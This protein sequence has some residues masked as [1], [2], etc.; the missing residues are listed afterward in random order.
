MADIYNK[1]TITPDYIQQFARSDNPV[2]FLSG[3]LSLGAQQQQAGM[4]RVKDINDYLDQQFQASAAQLKAINPAFDPKN[5]YVDPNIVWN[6]GEGASANRGAP[7]VQAQIKS[8]LQ[9]QAIKLAQQAAQTYQQTG[10]VTPPP[11]ASQ[12]VNQAWQNNGWTITDSNFLNGIDQRTAN[13]IPA[14]QKAALNAA[15][16]RVGAPLPYPKDQIG[17]IVGGGVFTNQD[18]QKALASG[19]TYDQI[20]QQAQAGTFQSQANPGFAAGG[21]GAPQGSQPAAQQANITPDPNN[22]GA[23]IFQGKSYRDQASA[24]TAAQHAGVPGVVGNGSGAGGLTTSGQAGGAAGTSQPALANNGLQAALDYLKNSNLDPAQ[25]DIF[26]SMLNDPA[27]GDKV[28]Y[29]SVV[30][31]LKNFQQNTLDPYYQEVTKNLINQTTS[32]YQ[33]L[34]QNRNLE[35]TQEGM[36]ADQ[37]IR[38]AKSDL[39]SRGMTFS[40]EGVRQLGNQSAFAQPGQNPN[41]AIPTQQQLPGG[42]F[43]EGLIPKQNQLIASSSAARY[44]QGLNQLSQGLESTLGT[45]GASG[46]VPG[47]QLLGGVTDRTATLPSQKNT[48]L[49]QGYQGILGNVTQNQQEGQNFNVFN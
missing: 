7:V 40:G 49:A 4:D 24:M 2:Q 11:P 19:Q 46:I 36:N 32:A 39:E 41:N 33:N 15:A 16:A 9:Q 48:Q 31:A 34:Q 29:N 47:G 12:I 44:Q 45:A 5:Y 18:I 37:N 3:D 1:T 23:F 6:P 20:A 21:V 27:L 17:E 14:D 35:T 28:D 42:G 26:T 43:A 30:T 25:K 38:N 10:Q 22:P 13:G 8:I